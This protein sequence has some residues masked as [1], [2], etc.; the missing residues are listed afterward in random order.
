MTV[1][2]LRIGNA[3]KIVKALTWFKY[4]NTLKFNASGISIIIASIQYT[5][6]GSS[7]RQEL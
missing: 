2:I 7:A 4:C 6:K 5:L 3:Q 1:H